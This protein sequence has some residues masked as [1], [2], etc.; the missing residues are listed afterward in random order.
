MMNH[1]MN[2]DA[3][4]LGLY[5]LRI[6]ERAELRRR[7]V[8]AFDNLKLNF[9]ASKAWRANKNQFLAIESLVPEPMQGQDILE[10]HHLL[11]SFL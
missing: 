5:L 4:L 11:A 9:S 2:P 7:I 3:Q 6:V 8:V 1:E 10:P